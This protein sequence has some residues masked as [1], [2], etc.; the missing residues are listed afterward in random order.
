MERI[1]QSYGGQSM[2]V[3]KLSVLEKCRIV[4]QMVIRLHHPVDLDRLDENDIPVYHQVRQMI[5]GE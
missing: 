2:K 3:R 5:I 1:Y 4:D